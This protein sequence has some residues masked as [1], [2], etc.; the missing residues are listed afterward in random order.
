ML[1]VVSPNPKPCSKLTHEYRHG[2]HYANI[3]SQ[4]LVKNFRKTTDFGLVFSLIKR[5]FCLISSVNYHS[6]NIGGVF[7]YRT[8]RYELLEVQIISL[9]VHFHDALK[10]VDVFG[11]VITL[12]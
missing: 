3:Y 7:N 8:S 2:E 4:K 12:N 9:R 11:G 10:F 5:Q 6:I 1:I